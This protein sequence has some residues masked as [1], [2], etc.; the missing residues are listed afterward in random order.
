MDAEGNIKYDAIVKQYHRKGKT[1]YSSYTDLIEKHMD[2]DE[3]AKPDVDE[4]MRLA[5]ETRKAFG[6]YFCI[7]LTWKEDS[8]QKNH[9]CQLI[10]YCLLFHRPT[11]RRKGVTR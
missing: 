6:S 7:V 10:F 4:E 9:S 5:E 1:V 11:R 2:D 8:H 3:L